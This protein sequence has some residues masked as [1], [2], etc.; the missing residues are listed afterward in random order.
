MFQGFYKRLQVMHWINFCLEQRN[1]SLQHADLTP[2]FI[3]RISLTNMWIKSQF[4]VCQT[5]VQRPLPLPSLSLRLQISVKRKACARCDCNC[6][7]PWWVTMWLSYK[8]HSIHLA[9]DSLYILSSSY[10]LV[11]PLPCQ[12]KNSWRWNKYEK[13]PLIFKNYLQ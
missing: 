10:S 4:L 9:R 2:V 7:S 8:L 11:K 6:I 13:N 5:S 1:K 3:V 12:G